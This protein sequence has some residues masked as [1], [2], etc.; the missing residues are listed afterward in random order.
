MV[1]T[2]QYTYQNGLRIETYDLGNAYHIVDS[3]YT[4][5]TGQ[6]TQNNRN[7][8]SFGSPGGTTIAKFNYDTKK[9]PYNDLNIA[10]YGTRGTDTAYAYFHGIIDYVTGPNTNTID[11]SFYWNTQ[12]N[13]LNLQT[14]KS[15]TYTYDANDYPLTCVGQH[16]EFV[17]GSAVGSYP[18]QVTY[19]YY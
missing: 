5:S 19:E 14:A 2:K 3:F 8:S 15:R 12:T 10:Q 7:A 9:N 16:D 11:S 13:T 4:N 17:S 6:L 18:L 1:Y